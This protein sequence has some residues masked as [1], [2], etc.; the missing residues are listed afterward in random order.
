MQIFLSVVFW[1]FLNIWSIVIP[2]IFIIPAIIFS[3]LRI[4]DFGAKIWSLVLMKAL[5]ILCGIDYRII[6]RKN[7]PKEPCIIA[8]KHQSMWETVIMHLI[9][10]R[11]VYLYK[12]ELVKVPFYGWFLGR[13]SGIVVDRKGGARALKNMVARAKVFL[14]AGQSIVIFPQGTRV[15]PEGDITKYPYQIG[16]AALYNACQVKVVPVALNSG[17]FWSRSKIFRNPGTIIIEFLPAIEPGLSKEEFN[18]T[19]VKMT[20][21]ACAK[22]SASS[23]LR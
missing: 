11:P 7:I 2:A 12:K 20:E 8:C 6:G 16:I 23:R 14:R 18:Q 1:I 17:V 4:A 22:L 15:P 3:S 10:H 5:K 9:L 19:L 13:M 21:N